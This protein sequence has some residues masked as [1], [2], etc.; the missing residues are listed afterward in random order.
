V[1]SPLLRSLGV[2]GL[3]PFIY[4]LLRGVG[5]SIRW[6]ELNP[7]P[8]RSLW[9]GGQRV[10]LAFWHNR[11]LMAPFFYRGRGLRILISRHTDGEIIRRVMLYFGF[12]SVRGSS[13]RGGAEAFRALLRSVE[14]GKDIVIT[15]DGP[16]GP[17]YKVQRGIVELAWKT[18]LPIIA[19]SFSTRHRIEIPSWDGL[20]LPRPFTQGVFIWDHPLWVPPQADSSQREFLREALEE[21]MK[22]IT[23]AADEYFGVLEK[24]EGS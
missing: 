8:A 9:L 10:I 3:P 16:R 15:P 11:M 12:G 23:Q 14:Q 24:R 7:E 22:L 4:W 20:V 5:R 18:G 1:S 17:R 6:V 13:T 21:R 19:V 2:R